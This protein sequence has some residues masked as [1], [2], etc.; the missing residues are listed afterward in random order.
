MTGRSE[1]PDGTRMT[2]TNPA[3]AAG[4]MEVLTDQLLQMNAA[5]MLNAAQFED[6]GGWVLKPR[7]YL[8][9]ESQQPN[10][11]RVSL[12]VKLRILA[13][14]GLGRLDDTP[15]VYAKCELHVESKAEAEHGQIPQGGKNKGGEYKQ[16]STMRHS[17]DPDFGGDCMLYRLI[18]A[19][20]RMID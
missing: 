10:P 13:A 11:N 7:G 3:K 19:T 6:S 18:K 14:Q 9:V 15:S 17:R 16:R 2:L 20:C 8:P 5:M 4:P 1:L 12:D